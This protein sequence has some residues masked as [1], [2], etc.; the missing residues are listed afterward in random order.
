[1]IN[2]DALPKTI[3][4]FIFYLEIVLGKSKSTTYEYTLDIQNFFRYLKYK[5]DNLPKNTP[6]HEVPIFDIELP[7]VASITTADIYD[8]LYYCREV[9]KNG[10]RSVARKMATLRTYFKYMTIK[11]HQLES[12]PM[13][14]IETPSPRKNLPKHLTLEESAELLQSIRH[15]RR[16]F[17]II[18]IFLNCGLRLAELVSL[19]IKDVSNEFVVVTGKGNKQ[20]TI[21]LNDA[22]RTA[23][24]D[25][26]N[27]ERPKEGIQDPEALFI[28][29]NRRRI[30]RRAVQNIVEKYLTLAGLGG[31]HLS[32]HK[33]RHTAATLMHRYGEVDIRVL[34][35]VLGHENLSTTQIYVHVDSEQIKNASMQNPLSKIKRK[36]IPNEE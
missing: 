12:N 8:Y 13:E 27:H 22:C 16:D 7:F 36:T 14:K 9:R 1:M 17:A 5:K 11:T 31:Q 18:T 15:S 23:I 28:S 35:D 19:N 3:K 34:Q 6:L 33:L 24:N 10:P 21:Y 20:R 32:T 4:D 26:V 30:S 25:Y 2:Y 29:R